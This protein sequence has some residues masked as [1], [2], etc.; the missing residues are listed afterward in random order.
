MQI[1]LKSI[2]KR[3]LLPLPLPMAN[4]SAKFLQL[5][6]NPLLTEDQLRMLKYDNCISGKFKNNFDLGYK[7]TKNLRTKST[8]I[9]ITGKAVVNSQIKNQKINKMVIFSY[10]SLFIAFNY[11]SIYICQTKSL[12]IEARRNIKDNNQENIEGNDDHFNENNLDQKSISDEI[13][14]LNNLKKKGC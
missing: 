7:A 8:N 10:W 9:V 1:L 12:G 13:L 2:E 3:I 14:R 6:P 5:F 4:L 11:S